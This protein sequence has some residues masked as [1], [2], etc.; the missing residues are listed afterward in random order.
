MKHEDIQYVII[1]IIILIHHGETAP[2]AFA[3][4]GRVP[5]RPTPPGRR[6]GQRR[7]RRKAG[8]GM[9]ADG[10]L[11]PPLRGWSGGKN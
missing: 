8:A 1:I 7:A 2:G 3:P 9:E 6:R 5:A 4:P 11:H 10:G